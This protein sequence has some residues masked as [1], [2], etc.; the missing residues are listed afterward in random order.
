MKKQL[1]LSGV[2]LA[3]ATMLTG[4]FS[5]S[6]S[7]DYADD[8]MGETPPPEDDGTAFVRVAH[9]IADAPE[10]DVFLNG[11]PVDGLTN[12]PFGAA[13]GFLEVP[14]GE[15]AVAVAPAG[16]GID[17]AL[18]F[19]GPGTLELDE[20]GVYTLAATHHL[21]DPWF[22]AY[23][24]SM[25]EPAEGAEIRIAHLSP[26]APETVWVYLSGNDEDLAD[27]DPVP[28]SYDGTD[29]GEIVD[30]L[31]VAPGEYRVRITL[32]EA[33]PVADN[34]YFDRRG[35]ELG[36]GDRV[37]MY[38]VSGS[39]ATSPVDL[40]AL[41]GDPESPVMAVTDERIGLRVVHAVQGG[42][43]VAVLVGGDE[44][45]TDVAYQDVSDYL[46]FG[47][48]GNDEITVPVDV[49]PG[50]FSDDVTLTAGTDYTAVAVETTSDGEGVGLRL[51]EDD[52]RQIP[53]TDSLVR[54]FHAVTSAGLVDE[55]DVY[56]DGDLIQENLAEGTVSD[57][58]GNAFAQLPAGEYE[59]AVTVA[60]AALDDALLTAELTPGGRNV[61]TVF[62][63]G[64]ESE[65]ATVGLQPVF[66]ANR[67][68]VDPDA[69]D[70]A[71]AATIT[72]NNQ[73][74]SAWTFTDITGNDELVEVAMGDDNP[75]LSLTEEYR[76]EI[77]NLGTGGHPLE[78]LDSEGNVLLDQEGNGSFANDDEVN[79]ELDGDR[80][81]FTLTPE[82]A[83]ALAEYRCIVHP[84]SMVGGIALL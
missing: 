52:H 76:Y 14:A 65:L 23:P 8:G 74:A 66:D 6:S 33:E 46:A 70:A 77:N 75:T 60:G 12:V 69:G 54:I 19:S 63:F 81:T 40:L 13:S 10:V 55:V 73:G 7:D 48:G 20:D 79:V 51:L 47:T 11:E 43:E 25:E 39:R 62:A 49:T 22:R 17:A 26:D 56:L 72:M 82:L 15:A 32:P 36:A 68:V 53:A 78:L 61:Y 34:V 4:C 80:M 84:G 2:A 58:D 42:P 37:T 30:Y 31:S 67:P 44:V 28:V 71:A 9:T 35:V 45:L 50:V 41:T 59:A 27:V 1:L 29:E 3:T 21:N 64:R 24:D 18:D 57:F 5:S 16:E 83:A 38:A